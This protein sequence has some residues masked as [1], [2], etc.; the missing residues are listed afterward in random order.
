MPLP[1]ITYGRVYEIQ[2]SMKVRKA[3]LP[4]GTSPHVL[5]SE[6]LSW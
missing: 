1:V 5:R 6:P 3:N 2:S 4:D